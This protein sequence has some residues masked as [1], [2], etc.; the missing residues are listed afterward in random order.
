MMFPFPTV[1]VYLPFYNATNIEYYIYFKELDKKKKSYF[2][3]MLLE[4]YQEQSFLFVPGKKY[5]LSNAMQTVT[6]DTFNDNESSREGR[7][8]DQF[9][10]TL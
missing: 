6:R 3:R 9:L 1:F 10:Q 7:N 4:V 2:W 5:T 8:D